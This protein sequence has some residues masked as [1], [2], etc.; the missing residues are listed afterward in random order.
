MAYMDLQ[1]DAS[2]LKLYSSVALLVKV[3]RHPEQTMVATDTDA[4]DAH[5]VQ[6]RRAWPKARITVAAIP[7]YSSKAHHGMPL[8]YYW[9]TDVMRDAGV[10]RVWD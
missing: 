10:E 2:N 4:A 7:S 6:C 5:I 8:G 3:A 9:Y 1:V